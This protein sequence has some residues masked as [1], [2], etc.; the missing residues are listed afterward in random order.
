MNQGKKWASALIAISL[1]TATPVWA[2]ETKPAS[3]SQRDIEDEEK[4]KELSLRAKD[5]VQAVINSNPIFENFRVQ[6]VTEN[7]QKDE[8]AWLVLLSD[9]PTS[10]KKQ[11]GSYGTLSLKISRE[12]GRL[13]YMYYSTPDGKANDFAAEELV[14]RKA[15][16]FVGFVNQEQVKMDNHLVLDSEDS[17]SKKTTVSFYKTVNGLAVKEKWIEVAVNGYGDVTSYNEFNV[18]MPAADKFANPDKAISKED[19]LKAFN[20]QVAMELVY[21][22]KQKRLKYVPSEWPMVDAITG[23]PLEPSYE[24]L[25]EKI[26]LDQKHERKTLQ[27]EQSFEELAADFLDIKLKSMSKT[28]EDRKSDEIVY[29][30]V[31]N[32]SEKA[33]IVVD[34]KTHHIKQIE[35]AGTEYPKGRSLLS[36]EEA[37]KKLVKLVQQY[38]GKAGDEYLIKLRAASVDEIPSWVDKNKLR[39]V[40]EAT[41]HPLYDGIPSAAPAFTLKINGY[42]GSILS[43]QTDASVLANDDKPDKS[44][45]ITPEEARK[46][47][48]Q[49]LNLELSYIYPSF[50]TQNSIQPTLVYQTT[51][52][53]SSYV[54]P[55]SGEMAVE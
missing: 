27:S 6:H 31:R 53:G 24:V 32:I 21:D 29:S 46:A 34:A 7:K 25:K 5:I 55:S 48:V 15:K 44:K 45:L 37:K 26:N 51:I 20:Q 11:E 40:Y 54:N 36:A 19:A 39:V 49:K 41:V 35:L 50:F 13:L 3:K 8:E 12:T 17:S 22:T 10:P 38:L 47:F 28:G 43:L 33:T 2:A 18:D 42:T 23:K 4:L 52:K 30:W 1:L 16:E 14:K 9:K